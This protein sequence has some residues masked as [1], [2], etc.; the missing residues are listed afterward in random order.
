VAR[1]FSV[2]AVQAE[3]QRILLDRADGTQLPAPP[4]VPDGSRLVAVVNNGEWQ[5]AVDVTYPAVYQKVGRR[6]QEGVWKAMDLYL[7]DERRAV[8]IEDARR[9]TMNGQPIKDPGRA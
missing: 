4:R 7:I 6:Y 9:V 5:S 1:Y 3:G 8:Q 2:L